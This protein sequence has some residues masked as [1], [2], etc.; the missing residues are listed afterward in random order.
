MLARNPRGIRVEF[1]ERF[2][3][4]INEKS[5]MQGTDGLVEV[6]AFW[7]PGENEIKKLRWRHRL[8]WLADCWSTEAYYI[9][10]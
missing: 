9:S 1:S 7:Q 4:K 2:P 8:V 6:Y 3:Q 10:T 5:K